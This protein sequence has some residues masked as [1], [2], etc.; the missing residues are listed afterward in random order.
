MQKLSTQIRDLTETGEIISRLRL[1]EGNLKR[2]TET[3][4]F[5]E[6]KARRGR[7][8]DVHGTRLVDRIDTPGDRGSPC[9]PATQQAHSLRWP[10]RPSRGN[11]QKQWESMEFLHPPQLGTWYHNRPNQ[12]LEDELENGNRVMGMTNGCSHI[13][14]SRMRF[15]HQCLC[16]SCPNK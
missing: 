1:P 13:W 7:R 4:T 12:N 5:E 14:T 10:A 2:L 8:S 11:L 16:K 3:D 6:T 15:L 9:A